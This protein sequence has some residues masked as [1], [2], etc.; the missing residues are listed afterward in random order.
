MS[1]LKEG[2]KYMTCME[3]SLLS[4][5]NFTA[6]SKG[7]YQAFA[8]KIGEIYRELK[9]W[10]GKRPGN[11]ELQMMG[12][13]SIWN[14]G[15]VRTIGRG[16]WFL[17]LRGAG[18]SV[19]RASVLNIPGV[20]CPPYFSHLFYPI[21]FLKLS[22]NFFSPWKKWGVTKWKWNNKM[23]HGCAIHLFRLA[24]GVSFW[25]SCLNCRGH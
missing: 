5:V 19:L 3:I 20:I 23:F 18:C 8:W 9:C 7:V 25:P 12:K 22:W 2:G 10:L 21:L 17:L 24:A 15:V 1:S 11:E 6:E 14:R 13:Y 4:G 16:S